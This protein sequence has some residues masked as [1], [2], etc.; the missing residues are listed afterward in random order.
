MEH[1]SMELGGPHAASLSCVVRLMFVR[2]IPERRQRRVLNA[3]NR[4]QRIRPSLDAVP[5]YY[6]GVCCFIGGALQRPV[7]R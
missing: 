3:Q 7:A 4:L 1:G 5:V 2:E 6:N